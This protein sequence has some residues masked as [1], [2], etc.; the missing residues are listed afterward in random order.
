METEQWIRVEETDEGYRIGGALVTNVHSRAQCAAHDAACVMHNPT[1]HH[2]SSWTQLWREDRKIVERMCGHGVGHP[3]PDQWP[4][5]Q[6][7]N[8]MYEQVHGCCGCC[9]AF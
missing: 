5:W 9:R 4:H 1:E 3:D 8:R 7:T 2:M 6:R